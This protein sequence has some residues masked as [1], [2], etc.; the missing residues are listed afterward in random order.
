MSILICSH[1]GG[2]F[3]IQVVQSRRNNYFIAVFTLRTQLKASS[4]HIFFFSFFDICSFYSSPVIFAHISHFQ[5]SAQERL[6][7]SP[8]IMSEMK[9]DS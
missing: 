2:L 4:K 9:Y 7:P 6:N 8:D 5:W 3:Q 1:W